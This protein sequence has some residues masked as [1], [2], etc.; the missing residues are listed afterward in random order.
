MPDE[1]ERD[2]YTQTIHRN[3]AFKTISLS[4]KVYR[5]LK[6]EKRGGE[7]FSDVIERL[8]AMKQPSLLKY[9]GAWKRLGERELREIRA[10]IEELRHK[11]PAR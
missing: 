6:A 8:L 1:A 2:I 4:D 9:A 7:S 10:R 3:V 11:T 5:K